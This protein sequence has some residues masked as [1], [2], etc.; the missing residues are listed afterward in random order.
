[1]PKR[2]CLPYAAPSAQS[3]GWAVLLFP[4]ACAA[5]PLPAL[6]QTWSTMQ[7]SRRVEGESELNVEVKYGT[8]EFRVEPAPNGQL[9]SLNLR[10][11]EEL[12]T[13]V[14]DFE[15]NQLVVGVEKER[16]ASIFHRGA[17]DGELRLALTD[18]VPM[19]LDLEF[20]AVEAEMELGG[21]RL[22]SLNLATGAS[23]ANLRVS[24]PNPEPMRSVRLQVGAASLQTSGLGRLN[25]ESVTVEAGVGDVRLDF[26]GLQRP[27]TQV[28]AKMGVGSLEIRVPRDAG[29]RLT[30]QSFLTALEA[31]GLEHRGEEYITSN[32]DSS[33]YRLFIDVEAAFGKVSVVRTD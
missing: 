18:R 1:M 3:L 2:D 20:G 13:P 5:L 15:G 6:A 4:V 28:K 14:H 23:D 32:W 17:R 30:R 10:Y 7:A 31:P 19:D 12:F 22:R 9:Y 29:I 25:A 21:M 8:G 26:T 33:E 11:D 27:T 24:S 16:G